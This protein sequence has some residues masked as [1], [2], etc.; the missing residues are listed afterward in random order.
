L[1]PPGPYRPRL[2]APR[3]LP[4]RLPRQVDLTDTAI[5]VATSSTHGRA[6]H[7]TLRY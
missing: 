2:K 5:T 3:S 1:T 4:G 7:R 6:A